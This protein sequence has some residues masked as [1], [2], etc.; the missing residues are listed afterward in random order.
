MTKAT[1]KFIVRAALAAA[2][3]TL[4]TSL[5][6]GCSISTGIGVG[7]MIAEQRI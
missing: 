1:I 4:L 2:I 6:F 3:L 5:M 7:L